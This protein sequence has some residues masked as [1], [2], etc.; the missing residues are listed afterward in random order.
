MKLSKSWGVAFVILGLVVLV[1]AVA[2]FV[3]PGELIRQKVQEKLPNLTSAIADVA[4]FTFDDSSA[5]TDSGS[6]ELDMKDVKKFV[7]D[8]QVGR[9]TV[10][11]DA[12]ANKASVTYVKKINGLSGEEA[13]RLLDDVKVDISRNGDQQVVRTS[14]PD[15]EFLNTKRLHVDFEIV[16]PAATDLELQ[17]NVGEVDTNGLEG[18]VKAVVNVGKLS[19]DGYKGTLSAESSTGEVTVRGGKDIKSVDITA[20]VGAVHFAVSEQANLDVN[21]ETNIGTVNTDFSWGTSRQ[22]IGKTLHGKIGDGTGG[23]VRLITN[24]GAIDIN[25]E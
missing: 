6:Q 24:T 23:H 9:I 12:S 8:N 4:D 3:Q 25:K 15:G 7:L 1:G 13:K 17:N 5:V 11:G 2:N 20:H 14:I 19:I 21:A 16:L 22:G 10:T 18:A